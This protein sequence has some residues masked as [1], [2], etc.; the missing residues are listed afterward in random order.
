MRP[1]ICS[2]FVIFLA[3]SSAL[4]QA[5]AKADFLVRLKWVKSDLPTSVLT[6]CIAV[7]SDGRFHL[8][9]RSDWPQSKTQ[10]Y[11]DSLADNDIKSLRTIIDD[12]QLKDLS[13]IDT[14]G[15]VVREREHGELVWALISRGDTTQKLLF[16]SQTGTPERRSLAL[17]KP[18]NALVGWGDATAKDL[19]QRKVRP[20]KNARPAM[21][22]L[23][24]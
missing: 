19:N 23:V 2:T 17:P 22:W 15:I 4:A 13:G 8:E 11:E 21:C 10:V 9:K 1:A 5:P 6:T 12:P 3:M 14:G 16:N 24:N 20:L 18:L 7:F